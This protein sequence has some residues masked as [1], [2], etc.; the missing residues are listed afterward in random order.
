[1]NNCFKNMGGIIMASIK[2]ESRRRRQKKHVRRHKRSM[3]L[4]SMTIMMLVVIIFVSGLN[5]RAKNKAYQVQEAKLQQE[6]EE[7]T[8]RSE[9]IEELK[10]YVG[11]DKH[12]EEV[13]K[14][15]LGL[16]FDG[17]ILFRSQQ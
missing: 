17:E 9:E 16:V 8:A 2:R 6:I 14:E 10:G 4:I 1:M 3:M 13:A 11:T 15:K 5:L 12:I 7:E